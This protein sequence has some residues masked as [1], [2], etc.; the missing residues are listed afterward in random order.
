MLNAY[1]QISAHG[2]TAL[3]RQINLHTLPV[4]M[5][6]LEDVVAVR[7][8]NADTLA[9][10]TLVSQV[11]QSGAMWPQLVAYVSVAAGHSW[12]RMFVCTICNLS[13]TL[14]GWHTYNLGP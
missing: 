5:R 3:W 11:S 9:A 14:A 12:L 1:A 8:L 2:R 6:C 4:L 13:Q 7:Q 10:V